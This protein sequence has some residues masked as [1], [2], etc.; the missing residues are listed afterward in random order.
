M[1]RLTKDSSLLNS[2]FHSCIYSPNRWQIF[3]EYIC[4]PYHCGVTERH[5]T[6][7]YQESIFMFFSTLFANCKI[8]C[9]SVFYFW[10]TNYH[11]V[12]YL[13]ELT[14]SQVCRFEVQWAL[15]GSLLR[16]SRGGNQAAAQLGSQLEALEMNLL[17]SPFRLLDKSICVCL[18]D[19][20]P[21][22]LTARQP[23]AALGSCRLSVSPGSCL[24]PCQSQLPESR[25]LF[26][27]PKKSPAFQGHMLFDYAYLNN[28]LFVI[29]Y[30]H[31]N[32][33]SSYS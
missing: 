25:L 3:T 13:K 14:V 17:H 24:P 27:L 33:T 12:S 9:I 21:C 11:K 22:L 15:L 18:Y 32:V 19:Q 30:S 1:T 26:L 6:F 28:L 5:M 8:L 2:P 31:R 16:V 29:L 7:V 10:I 23:G 20:G 4:S